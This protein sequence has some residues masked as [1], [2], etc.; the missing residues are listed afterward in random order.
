M[1]YM[2]KKLEITNEG[3]L[4]WHLAVKYEF[5]AA[6]TRVLAMQQAYIEKVARV[7]GI[8]PNLAKGPKTPL[9]P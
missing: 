8:D 6:K 5:N 4:S 1:Q 9:D 2:A 7:H 3:A